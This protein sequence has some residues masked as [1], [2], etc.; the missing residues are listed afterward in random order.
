MKLPAFFLIG[1]AS[2]DGLS[3]TNSRTTTDLRNVNEEKGRS[4]F[5]RTHVLNVIAVWELPVGRGKTFA[6]FNLH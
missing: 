5:D 2:G 6:L 3:T 1:A 4:D